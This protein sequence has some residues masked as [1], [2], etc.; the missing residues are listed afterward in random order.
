MKVIV[1]AHPQTLVVYYETPERRR[2]QRLLDRSPFNHSIEIPDGSR[3]L[4]LED[5][6]KTGTCREAEHS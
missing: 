6:V 1:E 4:T 3:L 2:F 5:L